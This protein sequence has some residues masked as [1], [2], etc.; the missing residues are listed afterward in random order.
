MAQEAGVQV[1]RSQN[2]LVEVKFKPGIR[3]H[4]V[5]REYEPVYAGAAATMTASRS[6]SFFRSSQ[7]RPHEFFG[8]RRP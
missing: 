1:G 3:R 7:C 4:R 6:S 2:G 5:F 8:K